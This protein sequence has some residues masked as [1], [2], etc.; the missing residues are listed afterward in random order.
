M[1]YE[2]STPPL[3][4]GS[5]PQVSGVITVGGRTPSLSMMIQD[6]GPLSGLNIAAIEWG[7]GQRDQLT[8]TPT[9]WIPAAPVKVDSGGHI[10]TSLGSFT[11]ALVLTDLAGNATRTSLGTITVKAAPKAPKRISPVAI[12]GDPTVGSTLTCSATFSGD[13]TTISYGW[14]RNDRSVKVGTDAGLTLRAP[15]RMGVGGSR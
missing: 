12:S 8:V 5:A 15:N 14:F 2:D 6:D 9:A 10:F 13:P 3:L 11:P 1:T 7:D 4:V